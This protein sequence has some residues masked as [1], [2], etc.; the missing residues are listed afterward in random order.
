MDLDD[1]KLI[2]QRASVGA[3]AKAMGGM[4][5]P[6]A[7]MGITLPTQQLLLSG[8]RMEPSPVLMLLN[9]VTVEELVDDEDYPGNH[10]LSLL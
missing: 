9:M 3:T 5:M 8:G 2:V 4:G 7:P 10:L 6:M 1:K